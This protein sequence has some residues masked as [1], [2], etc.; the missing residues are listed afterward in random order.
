MGSCGELTVSKYCGN[1][2]TW[3]VPSLNWAQ[4]SAI[5]K[6]LLLFAFNTTLQHPNFA[7]Y[8]TDM[9]P[10]NFAVS[11]EGI[12]RLVD[13]EHVIVVDKYPRG[14]APIIRISVQL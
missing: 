13:L 7:F 11:S 1:T 2:L 12:V 8:F 9:T 4:R 5:A 14:K 3:V 10:D 6:Q